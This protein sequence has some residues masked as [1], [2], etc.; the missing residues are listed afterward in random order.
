MDTLEV[1]SVSPFDQNGEIGMFA[2]VLFAKAGEVE[3]V[4]FIASYPLST[5]PDQRGGADVV[6]VDRRGRVVAARPYVEGS[7]A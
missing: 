2:A 1:E 6:T 4:Q 7:D 3:H 5:D